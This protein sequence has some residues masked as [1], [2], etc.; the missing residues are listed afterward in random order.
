MLHKFISYKFLYLIIL[1]KYVN[2][3]IPSAHFV[4]QTKG[5]ASATVDITT[6]DLKVKPSQI[7]AWKPT[8][9]TDRSNLTQH[10]LNLSKIRLTSM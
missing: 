3:N 6:D 4:N 9:S 5:K 10:Y 7:P 8:P 2:F 1:Q